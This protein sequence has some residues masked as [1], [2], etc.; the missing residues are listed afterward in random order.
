MKKK[1]SSQSY[2]LASG[3]KA[4]TL[5]AL[6]P[7]LMNLLSGLISTLMNLAPLF[8]KARKQKLRKRH[9]MG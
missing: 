1:S 3:G 4:L 6:C 2:V 9:L 5:Q 8:Q 7:A